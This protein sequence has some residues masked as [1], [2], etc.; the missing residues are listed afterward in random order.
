VRG[1]V[2]ALKIEVKDMNKVKIGI[3]MLLLLLIPTIPMLPVIAPPLPPEGPV[4]VDVTKVYVSNSADEWWSG[5]TTSHIASGYIVPPGDAVWQNAVPVSWPS[6]FPAY[7]TDRLTNAAYKAILFGAPGPS[8]QWIWSKQPIPTGETYTGDIVFFRKTVDIPSDASS[9]SADLYMN[10]DNGYYFYIN[11]PSWSGT[12]IGFPHI[13]NG[14]EPGYDPTNF[15]YIGDSTSE[16]AGAGADPSKDWET[17]GNLYPLNPSVEGEPSANDGQ[18]RYITKYDV[19]THLTAGSNKLQVVAV[20]EHA[21]PSVTGNP[22][23]LIYKLV[24]SYQQPININLE[25]E[26]D[27]VYAQEGQVIDYTFK[28]TNTGSLPLSGIV[29]TDDLTSPPVY[30]SG[31]D[32]DGILQVGEE[33]VYT[34]SYTVPGGVNKVE[35]EATVVGYYEGTGVSDKD[36]WS[37][38]VLP[39]SKVTSSSLCIFDKNDDIPGQQFRLIFTN[40]PTTENRYKLTASN[41][42]QFYYNIFYIG[43]PG[44]TVDIEITIPEPFET[45]GAMPVHLYS[46]VSFDGTCFDPDGEFAVYPASIMIA[47]VITLSDVV[48]PDTGLVYVAVHLDYGWKKEGGYYPDKVPDGTINGAVNDDSSLDIV[49][50]EDYDFS[51]EVESSPWDTQTIEAE[52]VFKNDPGFYGFVLTGEQEPIEGVNVQVIDPEG[53]LLGTVSTDENG[54]YFFFWKHK[55]REAIYTVTLTDYGLSHDVALKSNKFAEVNFEL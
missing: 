47:G 51:C 18:W 53:N 16:N 40:D 48:V 27:T 36:T 15:Y 19:S 52:L 12:P 26:G 35:N 7:W 4:L 2:Y 38:T 32:S 10:A 3:L 20:N 28:V 8:A 45:Q 11:N 13:D 31:D 55:G 30:V 21:P 41:P 1:S 33:W 37:I 25:K 17:D 42:G 22:G 24:I 6:G 29:L 46:E 50:Y 14:F 54:Y 5:A 34:A 43:D 49:N 39:F 9:I 23:S 44:S